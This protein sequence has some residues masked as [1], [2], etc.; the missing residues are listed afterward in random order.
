MGAT[1]HVAK[2]LIENLK[3]DE[4]FLFSRTKFISY[5]FFESYEYDA[6]INC[7]GYGNPAD[8][9]RAGPDLF[10]VTEKYDNLVLDYLKT[11]EDTKYIFISSGVVHSPIDINNITK[12]SFYQIPKINAEVKHRALPEY[13]IADIRLFSFFTRYTNLDSGFFMSALIKAVKENKE[14]ITDESIM[15]R[16]YIDPRDLTSLIKLCISQKSINNALDI[17][18]LAACDKF[19]VMAYFQ[20]KYNLKIKIVPKMDS[21]SSVNRHIYVSDDVMRDDSKTLKMGYTPHYT[22]LQTIKEESSYLL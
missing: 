8:I 16:D 3:G 19:Q 20:E 21:F 1:G 2:N 10:F 17:Y 22:S 7:I 12:Q 6:I 4:I 14:F 11:H 15:I 9:E 5:D 18:S 13:N